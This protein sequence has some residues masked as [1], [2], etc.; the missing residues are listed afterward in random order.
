MAFE[1]TNPITALGLL[2]LHTAVSSS[3]SGGEVHG[4]G[5]AREEVQVGLLV[6]V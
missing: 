4:D 1:V 3:S 2:L 5:E 6:A